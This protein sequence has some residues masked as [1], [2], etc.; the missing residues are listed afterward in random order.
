MSGVESEIPEMLT[1]GKNCFLNT[2]NIYEVIF[3]N[4]L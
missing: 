4:I 1:W 3:M 2:C